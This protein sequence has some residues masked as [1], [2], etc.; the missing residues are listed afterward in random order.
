M[1]NKNEEDL[2]NIEE[3]NNKIKDLEKNKLSFIDKINNLN[4]EYVKIDDFNSINSN[5]KSKLEEEV[6]KAKISLE[7]MNNEVNELSKNLDE[8]EHIKNN[9]FECI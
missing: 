8:K 9:I 2:K 5:S 6:K 3:L 7:K 1:K 4:M